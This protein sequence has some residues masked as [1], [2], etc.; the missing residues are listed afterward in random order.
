MDVNIM[1][2]SVYK[3]VLK[4]PDLKKLPPSTLEIGTYT[5]DTVKNYWIMC[6]LSGPPEH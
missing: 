5:T 1:P 3:L 2:S 4:D 6:F